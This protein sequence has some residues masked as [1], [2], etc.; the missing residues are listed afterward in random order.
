MTPE[1]VLV[2]AVCSRETRNLAELTPDQARA[3]ILRDRIELTSRQLQRDLRRR[4]Q[5]DMRS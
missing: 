2:L 1:G 4:A 3:Q 5:I